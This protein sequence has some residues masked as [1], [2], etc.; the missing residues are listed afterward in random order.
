M[1]PEEFKR[2]INALH[3]MFEHDP[4]RFHKHADEL[5]CE[6]L[7]SFGYGAGIDI[8]ENTKKWYS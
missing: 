4:E 8:F 3:S 1:T 2:T 6:L 5:M 7:R